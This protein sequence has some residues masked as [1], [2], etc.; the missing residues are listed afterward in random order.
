MNC[1]LCK[2]PNLPGDAQCDS[3]GASLTQEDIPKATTIFE[4]H[5]QKDGV[6]VLKPAVPLQTTV[7]TTLAD[8]VATMRKK[9]IG[10][11]VVTGERGELVGLLSERDFML[12]VALETPDLGARTVGEVMTRKPETVQ[13]SDPIAYAL[14]R[15]MVADLRHLPV[16][17]A[18][19]RPVGVIS[20]RDV[21]RYVEETIDKA[22]GER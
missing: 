2:H 22:R 10:C 13:E 6:S 7:D 18:D 8:A 20:S 16:I 9:S 14:Q 15:L 4:R 17:D 1:P 3:C 5:L 19:N 11:L 21:I 12:K